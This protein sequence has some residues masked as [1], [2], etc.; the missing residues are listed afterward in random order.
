MK[1]R[2]KDWY[3][4]KGWKGW[5]VTGPDGGGVAWF[6]SL[7]R[8]ANAQEGPKGAQAKDRAWRSASSLAQRLNQ[9]GVARER[10]LRKLAKE[11]EAYRA[12]GL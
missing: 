10:T 8:H 9:G 4:A 5:Q 7:G 3:G 6:Y 2:V 1:A 11:R 12:L